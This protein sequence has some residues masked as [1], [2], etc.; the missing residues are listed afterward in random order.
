MADRNRLESDRW[1]KRQPRVR[2]PPPLLMPATRMP[3]TTYRLDRRFA[4]QTFGWRM[5]FAGVFALL[6]FVCAFALDGFLLAFGVVFAAMGLIM[7]VGAVWTMMA[8]PVIASLT[9]QGFR[10]GRHTATL[11][12]RA[13]WTE[14]ENV[15][16]E[17]GPA[18][19]LLVFTVDSGQKGVVPLIL[20]PRRAEELQREVH[21]RL[22]TAHGYRRL[23]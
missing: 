17:Q 1:R 18:G 16:T 9:A 5:V 10:L 13:D 14:V 20:L 4:L 7:V 19:T 2:I 8:P 12:R 3:T 23:N 11:V 21:E 15:G 22:N 6:A